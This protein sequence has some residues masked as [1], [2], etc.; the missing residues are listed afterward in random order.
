M[1][2]VGEP[3]NETVGGAPTKGALLLGANEAQ[4]LWATLKNS[5]GHH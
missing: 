3:E 5:V 2:L 1:K 4:S